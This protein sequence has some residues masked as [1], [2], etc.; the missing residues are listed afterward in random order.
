[1]VLALM[2]AISIRQHSLACKE[3]TQ[4]IKATAAEAGAYKKAIALQCQYLYRKFPNTP[5]L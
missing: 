1:M 5:S 3:D 4:V 2:D